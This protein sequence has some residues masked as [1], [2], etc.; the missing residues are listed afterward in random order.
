MIRLNIT[1]PNDIAEKL[2]KEKNKSR[3]IAEALSEKFR[4][5]EKKRLE[6]LMIEGYKA[7]REE[8][9]TIVED[10]DQAGLEKWD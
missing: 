8:D 4:R 7:S 9:N 3:Y 10:W 1:I 5:E 6:K 2:S